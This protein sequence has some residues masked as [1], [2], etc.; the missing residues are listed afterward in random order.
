[1]AYEGYFYGT[2]GQS[3]YPSPRNTPGKYRNRPN[4]AREVKR[5]ISQYD[6]SELLTLS[7]SLCCRVPALRAAIRDKNNWAFASWSPAYMGEDQKWG[8]AAEEYLNHVVLPHACFRE[9]RSDFLWG[10]KVSGMG[11]D[12]HGDDLAIFTEHE[13]GTAAIDFIPAPRIGN[14]ANGYS[15]TTVTGGTMGIS[16]MDGQSLVTDG[17]FKGGTIYN[18]IIR[19]NGKPVAVRVIGFDDNGNQSYRDQPID[20]FAHYACEQEFFGQGRGLPRPASAITKWLSMEEIEQALDLGITAASE[21]VLIH[22]L[23]PGQDAAS[24]RG[25]AVEERTQ[26]AAGVD[27]WGNATGVTVD[28]PLFV[29][30]SNAGNLTFVAGDENLTGLDFSNPHPNTEAYLI[31]GTMQALADVGWSWSL[32]DSTTISR[33]PTRLETSKANNSITERQSIQ[34]IRSIRFFQYA[35]KKGMML[36]H[37]PHNNS[38]TDPYMWGVGFPAQLS[39]DTGN[40]VKSAIDS[41]KMGW[42]SD[43]IEAQKNG[44]NSRHILHQR[45]KEYKAKLTAANNAMAFAQGL[46]HAKAVTFDQHMSFFYQNSPNPPQPLQPQAADTKPEPAKK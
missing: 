11:M 6:H 44:Y 1:M 23:A 21:R 36:G 24:S 9:L 34:E 18:G 38:A 12:I 39:V 5:S 33:A 17:E 35:I 26:L 28:K 4:L 37:I 2:N 31:R 25:N 32:I 42:T 20:A 3:I 29:D 15:S 13:D 40:D 8:D 46:E 14:G 30:R 16:R 27:A 10:I 7:T 45:E 43:R 41:L 22:Q 19:K